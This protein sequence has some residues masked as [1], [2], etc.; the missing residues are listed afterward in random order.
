[1][2]KTQ[3]LSPSMQM[4]Q[5]LWPAA[6]VVQAIHVAA[7]FGLADLVA[8]GPKSIEELAEATHTHAS[9]L[10]RFLR[11]LTSLG[12]F[13]EDTA[14]TYRQ[15]ALSDTLRIDHPQSIRPTA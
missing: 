13:A 5:M 7:K 10:G 15:T 14:G 3:S 2:R 12:I 6:I 9:S 11:A 1:M 8:G 4:V